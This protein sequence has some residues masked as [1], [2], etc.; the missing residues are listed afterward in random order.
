MEVEIECV[1][2][3]KDS[4]E[5]QNAE[6]EK[7]TKV[8]KVEKFL[9]SCDNGTLSVELQQAKVYLYKAFIYHSEQLNVQQVQ[10]IIKDFATHVDEAIKNN[11]KDGNDN[12]D[13][14]ADEFLAIQV[15][16]DKQE[17]AV[18]NILIK[19]FENSF[20]PD[21]QSKRI[22]IVAAW[23]SLEMY[24]KKFS[25]YR[26]T[27]KKD[28]FLRHAVR[29]ENVDVVKMVLQSLPDVEYK[30][31]AKASRQK[32]KRD[33]INFKPIADGSTAWILA[34][35]RKSANAQEEDVRSRRNAVYQE[36]QKFRNLD[37]CPLSVD[38]KALI[39][40]NTSESNENY[41]QT[42]AHDETY[43]GQPCDS[44][45]D[46]EMDGTQRMICDNGEIKE[47]TKCVPKCKVEGTIDIEETIKE[48]VPG[49]N[50]TFPVK[51]KNGQAT[52]ATCPDVGGVVSGV[53]CP[54]PVIQQNLVTN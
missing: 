45:N 34:L 51:C 2:S 30:S 23:L 31:G 52:T 16:S 49:G 1:N 12:S 39:N 9:V 26:L 27:K 48:Y 13:K 33:E 41:K 7:D 40:Q 8:K 15:D 5:V 3:E 53:V 29:N 42:M 50:N 22:E 54:T 11:F 10:S 19:Q 21:K 37:Q 14:Q 36:L 28:T 20:I 38:A 4:V 47:H 6:D 25:T 44:N 43:V 46:G 35:S 18:E 17:K 24:Q 32:V